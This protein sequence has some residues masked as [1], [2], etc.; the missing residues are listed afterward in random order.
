MILS[1]WCNQMINMDTFLEI[2]KIILPAFFVFLTAWL[3]LRTFMN[4]EADVIRSML[5]RDAENRRVDVMKSNNSITTP[6]RLKAYERMAIFCSRIEL[7]NLVSNTETN[8]QMPAEMYKTILINT[9][10]AEFNHNVTQ[11]VY[12][13]DELWNIILLAKKEVTQI[14]QKL[15]ADLERKYADESL[16]GVPS[17]KEFLDAMVEYL[18]ST[19]QIGSKQALNSIRKEVSVLFA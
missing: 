14:C 18:K 15:F 7:S 19:P 8:A 3:V 9:V 5:A 1:L 12:M 4:K 13:T 10:E 6:M 16:K 17:S 2:L 11:Q